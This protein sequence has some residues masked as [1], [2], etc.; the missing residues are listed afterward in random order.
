MK[1]PMSS[2]GVRLTCALTTTLLAL[3]VGFSS[4]ALAASKSSATGF[5]KTRLH[6]TSG[7]PAHAASGSLSGTIVRTIVALL[8][9]IAVIYGITWALKQ[10]RTARN[11]SV[12]DGLTQVASLALGPNRSVALVR[13]GAEL[14]LLG[15]A[16]HGINGIRV[17]SE[18]EAYEL[19]IPFD[20]DDLDT[21]GRMSGAQPARR[22][23]DALRRLTVR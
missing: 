22:V 1:S 12:G 20:P 18:E 21:P 14:H 6:L 13:V 17:F 3:A 16:E 4:P 15:V 8:I 9:V 23:V 19:G 7:S 10:S 5:E 2:Y 11:P